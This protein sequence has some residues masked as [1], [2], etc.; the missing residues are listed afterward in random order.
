MGKS[1]TKAIP[2]FSVP[3]E[4]ITP[5]TVTEH[6]LWNQ[7]NK[8]TPILVRFQ[9]VMVQQEDSPGTWN[10]CVNYSPYYVPTQI[11]KMPCIQVLS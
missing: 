5:E 2:R 7:E 4:S 1:E 11:G 8:A 9:F 10:F 3:P 6:I